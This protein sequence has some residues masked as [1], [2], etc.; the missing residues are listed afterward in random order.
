M[1]PLTP[2]GDTMGKFKSKAQI[3][4]SN[5]MSQPNE[6]LMDLAYKTNLPQY[7][8][9]GLVKSGDWCAIMVMKETGGLR[10]A[11]ITCKDQEEARLRRRQLQDCGDSK[12]SYVGSAS[13]QV[14]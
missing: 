1:A 11:L 10:M 13:I 12:P 9:S 5:L 2:D 14:K 6:F 4:A 3:N 8:S 7:I